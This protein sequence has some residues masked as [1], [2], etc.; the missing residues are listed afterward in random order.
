MRKI[1]LV[2][3]GNF[4]EGIYSGIKLIAGEQ[5]NISLYK[6]END[7]EALK[8]NINQE[9]SNYSEEI[10]CF[11][12]LAGGTPFNVCSEIAHT[13]NNVHVIGGV[14]LPL[15]LSAI[16]NSSDDN[17][18]FLNSVMHEG[19]ESIKLFEVKK[20]EKDSTDGI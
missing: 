18:S 2:G 15:L 4:A 5:D 9:V 3:H 7:K 12:D 8:H 10:Y 14:N 17:E 13:K 20:K 19:K 6:F 1:I 11:A 16:F